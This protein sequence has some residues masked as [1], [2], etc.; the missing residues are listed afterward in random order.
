MTQP[1]ETLRTD[2]RKFRKGDLYDPSTKAG[3][4]Y[5]SSETEFVEA[6]FC[7]AIERE[8]AAALQRREEDGADAARYRIWRKG[9]ASIVPSCTEQIIDDGLDAALAEARKKATE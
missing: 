6:G 3:T 9:T 5:V 4:L 8:L 1:S 7:A 2:I